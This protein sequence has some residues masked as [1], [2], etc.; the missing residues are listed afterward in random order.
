MNDREDNKTAPPRVYTTTEVG[1]GTR[2]QDASTLIFHVTCT[3][4]DFSYNVLIT[5]TETSD[6][7]VTTSGDGVATGTIAPRPLTVVANTISD[8]E[9]VPAR[10]PP[11]GG[12]Y[13]C[14]SS[15]LGEFMFNSGT[16]N[17]GTARQRE[18]ELEFYT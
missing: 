3:N 1:S 16:V 15:A 13:F 14:P 11:W 8:S 4:Y 17:N 6:F 9:Q 10:Y 7:G 18:R 2:L 12:D 5:A